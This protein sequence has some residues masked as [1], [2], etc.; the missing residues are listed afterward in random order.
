MKGPGPYTPIFHEA[1][2]ICIEILSKRDTF[3]RTEE[4]VDDY[5]K[6]GV[7]YVWVVNPINRRVWS[8]SLADRKEIKDGV[9]RT[10]NP[11]IEILLADVFAGL[12]DAGL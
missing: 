5:L 1:P 10:E 2:F 4:R 8:Y 7:P 9:L 12:D 3:A 6:F 11:E